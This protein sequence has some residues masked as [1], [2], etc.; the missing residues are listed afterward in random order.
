[1]FATPEDAEL[2]FYDAFVRGD[3]EAMR[4]VWL[5]DDSIICIH[6]GS[7]ILE[8]RTPVHASWA[9]ILQSPP[10]IRYQVEWRSQSPLLAVHVGREWVP[11]GQG[12]TAVLAATNVFQIT[13]QGWRML[14][15]QS[16]GLDPR[17]TDAGQTPIH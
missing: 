16:A 12:K 3:I 2:G 4:A 11:T 13:S 14:L 17:A 8:G 9:E 6:P 5:D 7:D 10:S 15:H 1:M